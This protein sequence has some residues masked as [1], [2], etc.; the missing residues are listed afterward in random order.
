MI[1]HTLGI[2]TLL[3]FAVSSLPAQNKFIGT[4][5][6]APCHRTEKQGKQMEI[7]QKSA[8]ASAYKTLTTAKANDLAKQKGFT[9]PAAETAD[10]LSCHVPQHDAKNVEKS[11][12]AQ[13]GV[14]CETCH[15]AG[16]AYK[17]MSIMKDR[18]KSIAAGMTEYK[19]AAAI[20]AKCRTCHNEKSPT[21][22][23]FNFEEYWNKIKHPVPKAG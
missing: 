19:D 18:A 23:G 1:K 20:E 9:T 16:S 8:H 3:L 21:F 7:W 12:N 17:N 15:G 4:K 13:E 14:Q 5:M 6:C 11:F 22:K 10:C 2:L